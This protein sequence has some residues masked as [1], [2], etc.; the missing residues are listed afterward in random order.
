MGMPRDSNQRI[1]L[2]R[3]DD[4]RRQNLVAAARRI[5]YEEQYQVN[6]AAVE[7]LLRD[8]SLTPNV[9]CLIFVSTLAMRL[10]ISISTERFL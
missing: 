2:A 1:K 8:E 5:I 6:S 9:V 7:A 4:A 10:I 3:I